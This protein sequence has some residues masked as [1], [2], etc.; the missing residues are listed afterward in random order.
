M[1]QTHGLRKLFVYKYMTLCMQREKLNTLW[2]GRIGFTHIHVWYEPY[3][4]LNLRIQK[5][6]G[7]EWGGKKER[8][9]E[10]KWNHW[11][12]G[13]LKVG[14]SRK[15]T[16][17]IDVSRAFTF[18]YIHKMLLSGFVAAGDS[19]TSF[20]ISSDVSRKYPMIDVHA[21][22]FIRN[23]LKKIVEM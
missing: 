1:H 10:N 14:I 15:T 6:G 16:Y 19:K 8:T 2:C 22:V 17:K 11:C 12:V 13:G 9:T 3:V 23:F 7:G 5:W 18:N 20:D 21:F 4:L